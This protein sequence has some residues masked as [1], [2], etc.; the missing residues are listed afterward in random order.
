MATF[1]DSLDFLP[2]SYLVAPKHEWRVMRIVVAKVSKRLPRLCLPACDYFRKDI[3]GGPLCYDECNHFVFDT[4]VVGK[5]EEVL[6]VL[7]ATSTRDP[8]EGHSWMVGKNYLKDYLGSGRV[9]RM[10]N[11]YFRLVKPSEEGYTI[12]KED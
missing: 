5:G 6:D 2:D 3:D 10:I 12:P 11:D 8:H 1:I 4:H 9:D 7:F